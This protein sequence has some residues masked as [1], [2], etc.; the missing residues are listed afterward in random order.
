[1]STV[2]GG[3][4]LQTITRRN[5]LLGSAALGA[6]SACGDST[7]SEDMQ[8]LG[9]RESSQ[10][11]PPFDYAKYFDGVSRGEGLANGDLTPELLISDAIAR[12]KR[13]NGAINAIVNDQYDDARARSNTAMGEG[14]SGQPT[15]IK[16]LEDWKGAPTWYGSRA[17]RSAPSQE[18][19]GDYVG[20][21][22]ENGIISLGK[23]TTPELGLISSTEPIVTG[24][25]RNPWNTD[26]IPGGSSGGAAAL[27]AARVVPFAQASDGGGSIRIPAACCGLFGL[28]PSR[29]ALVESDPAGG[30]ANISVNHAVT[31]SVRDSINL[32]SI[33]QN[34][35]TA[36]M[37]DIVTEPI[38]RRLKIAFA[39]NPMTS[40]M[41]DAGTRA[42]IESTA[43]LC[44]ELGHE[45]IDWS[46][47]VDGDEFV[48][49]FL[50][51]WSAGAAQFV[52][53]AAE[54]NGVAPTPENLSDLVEP[55]TM[56]LAGNF[57]ANQSNFSAVLQYL[58]DFVS[59]Y[60]SWF[61]EF[62][63]ILTP[64]VATVAPEIGV[65]SPVG[66]FGTVRQNV[67]D[68][69][70]FTAPM[71]VSGGAS[72]SVPLYWS[73]DGMPV[74]AMFSARQGDDALLFKL[75]LEL[76]NTRPWIEKT[77]PVNAEA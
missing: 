44:R 54:Y 75:A 28:K 3:I 38:D 7:V 34:D 73:E 33:S 45:V 36:L 8:P 17:F 35:R 60:D 5:V 31:L 4:Q 62:D 20:T 16:D 13:V 10:P 70:C 74:G 40:A 2:R 67:L 77:P 39:P 58:N 68:F 76:E 24:P 37:R 57:V 72:M 59:S 42:G 1:M 27:V 46:M 32:F 55:W 69:A 25:T 19:Y 71:N 30:G 26:R 43:Q 49:N 56:G 11:Q 14:Y 18:G 66:D 22:H 65:Q 48:E 41:L 29:G 53:R 47:P 12:A 21:W 6:L 52:Q 50:L 61:S 51:L 63:V 23:S 9:T 15:F 64:T